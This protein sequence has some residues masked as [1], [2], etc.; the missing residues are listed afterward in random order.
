MGVKRIGVKSRMDSNPMVSFIV[1][2]YN[3]EKYIKKCIQSI[4]KQTYNSLLELIIVDDGSEDNSLAICR[5]YESTFENVRVLSQKNQGV[6]VARNRGLKEAKGEWVAFVDSDD[7]IV[8]DFI[9]TVMKC[10]ESYKYD[11]I[12]FDYCVDEMLEMCENSGTYCNIYKSSQCMELV[13]GA[14]SNENNSSNFG[15]VSLRSPCSRVYRRS[16]LERENIYFIPNI[17]MGEDLLFNINAYLK[18]SE[19][20]YVRK[21]LYIVRQRT[22]SVSRSYISNM[23]EIDKKFYDNLYSILREFNAPDEIWELYYKEAFVGI[24]RC[25]KF[26]YFNKQCEL[27]YKQIKVEFKKMIIMQPYKKAIKKAKSTKSLNKKIVA[28]LLYLQFFYVLMIIY[29]IKGDRN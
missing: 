1:P 16:F 17:K 15:N 22:D 25:M 11:L 24:M 2:V 28:W 8:S 27:S 10:K 18:I 21:P 3:S 19:L 20:C 9:E 23:H 13:R 7:E 4:L 12:I 6:S 14:L 29:K 26:E 5:E